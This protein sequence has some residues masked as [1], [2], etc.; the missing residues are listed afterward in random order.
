[1]VRSVLERERGGES[2]GRV[3]N[4]SSVLICVY[5]RRK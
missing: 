4:F 2:A 5:L 1:L 3:L